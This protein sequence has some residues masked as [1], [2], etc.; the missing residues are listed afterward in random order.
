MRETHDISAARCRESIAIVGIG[1]RMPGARDPRQLWANLRDGVASLREVPRERFDAAG[2]SSPWGGFVDDVDAFDAAFFGISPREATCMDPQQR[3]A[4]ETAWDALDDGGQRPLS[5]RGTRTGVF[6]GAHRSE[7]GDQL[8]SDLVAATGRSRSGIAG[9]ISFALGLEGP[10]VVLDT[11]RSSSL[12]ALLFAC[13]SLR[14][15]ECS[16]ALAGGVNL[17]LEPEPSL[18]FSR[19]NMLAPDGRIKFCDARA[20]GIARSDGIGIVALKP[21]SAAQRDGDAIYAVVLGGAINHDGGRSGDLM[22]PSTASQAALLRAACDDARVLPLDLQYVE[23]H[24]TGTVVGD[25]V[26]VEALAR[27]LQPGRAPSA[28]LRIGS[29]KTNLGHTEAAAGIAGVIKV[30]LA[31]KHRRLPASLH[32]ETPNP[33]IDFD[34]IVVQRETGAWPDE[35]RPLVAGVTSLGLTGVNAHAILAEAP[36]APRPVVAARDE[37]LAISARG[38]A[39]LFELAS[40]YLQRLR[41]D[42]DSDLTCAAATRRSHLEDRIAV[43]GSSPEELAHELAAVLETGNLAPPR[44]PRPQLRFVIRGEAQPAPGACVDLLAEDSAFR[45]AL[46]RCDLAVNEL[47]GSSLLAELG[48]DTASSRLAEPEL[49]RVCLVA[50]AIASAAQWRAWGI[51]ADVVTGTGTGT[52]AAAQIAGSVT[53]EQAIELALQGGPIDVPAHELDPAGHVVELGAN[54]TRRTLLRTLAALYTRGFDV[55]WTRVFGRDAGEV[56]LP[57]YPWRRDR[58]WAGREPKHEA[59]P[60]LA[61]VS[62][63]DHVIRELAGVLGLPTPEAIDPRRGFRELGVTSLL[64]MELIARLGTTLGR[65]LPVSV[66]FDHPNVEALAAHLDGVRPAT[67]TA[68]IEHSAEPIALVGIGC[69]FPGG[70]NS[71]D[72]FWN[73][74]HDGVDAI[75]EVPATRWDIE[76][77]YDPEPGQPGKMRTRWGGFLDDLDQFDAAFFGISPREAE[78]M[79]PQ[80]RLLLEVAWDAL[81]RA[82]QATERLTGSSVGVF[83]GLMNN[84]DYVARKRLLD[85][86]T[87]IRAAHSTGMATSIAAGRIA[88]LLGLT[89]PALAVDTACSSSLVAVHLAIRSLRAGEC[90]MALAGGANAIVSPELSVAYSQAGMLSPTGRCRTFS[91][92]AD[93]YVRSEGCGIVVLKR[94]ADAIA[95]GDSVLAVIAGAAVNHDGR[96][97]GLTAPNGTAQRAVVRAALADAG[98]A[99]ED[100]DYVEA[101]GTGTRLGDPIEFHALGEVFASRSRE[102]PVRVGSVKTNIGHLEAAAGIAGLIKVVLALQ[103]REMP[104]HLHLDRPSPLLADGDPPLEIPTRLTPWRARGRRVAGVSSFGFSGTNA[105]VVLAEAPSIAPAASCERAAELVVLSAK[106]ETALRAIAAEHA[107]H[108]EAHPELALGDVAFTLADGRSHHARRLAVVATSRAELAGALADVA[109]GRASPR[110][111]SGTATSGTKTAWLFTGQG[112]QRAGMGQ[113]LAAE[114]PVF[115]S[116]LAD[117]CAAVDAHLERSLRDVMWARPGTPDAALL[118]ETGYTQPALFALE[119]AL[120]ALWRSWGAEPDLVTGH[121]IGEIAAAHV[122]GVLSLDDAARLVAARA[123]LMQALPRGGAMVSIAAPEAEVAAAVAPHARSVAI[124]AINGPA[125]VVISGDAPTALAIA[126]GFARHGIRTAQLAVS[127]AFHSPLMEPMLDDFRAIAESVAYRAPRTP[128]VGNVTGAAWGAEVATADYWVRHVRAPVRFADGLAAL[129]RAGVRTFVELGPRPTLVGMVPACVPGDDHVLL[130]SLRPDRAEPVAILDALGGWYASGARVDWAPVCVGA[131]RRVELPTYAWDRQ[132]Y[133]LTPPPVRSE[134]ARAGGRRIELATGGT[135][136]EMVLSVA[137]QPWLADHRVGGEVVVPAAALLRLLAI[138]SESEELAAIAVRAPLRLADG[139]AREVQVV[140]DSPRVRLFSRS[141]DAAWTEHAEAEMRP[142]G[143][144]HA[145]SLAEARARCDQ[146]VDIDAAY[147]ALAAIGLDYGPAFRALRELA[148]GPGEVIARAVA[149]ESWTDAELGPLPALVDAAL[150]AMIAGA[151]Q[152]YLPFTFERVLVHGLVPAAAWISVRYTAPAGADLLAADVT[153]LDDHGR[154]IVSL[155]GCRAKRAELRAP[156]AIYRLAWQAIDATPAA[157]PAGR[158]LVVGAMESDGLAARVCARLREAGTACTHVDS[159]RVRDALPAEH[160]VYLCDRVDDALGVAT[161][162]LELAQ[163]LAAHTPAPRVW[164]MTRGATSTDARELPRIGAAALWGL[165]RT[166][167]HEH[168]E[169]RSVLVDLPAGEGA[170]EA[171]LAELATTDGETELAWRGGRRFAARLERATDGEC[172]GRALRTEGT[173]LVTGGLGGIGAH[174]ARWLAERG[175][176]HLVLAGRRGELTPGARELVDELRGRGALVTVAAVDVA[177]R[178][179]LSAVL[180]AIPAELPLRGVVHAAGTVDDGVLAEQTG[181]RFASVMAPKVAGAFHLD[182]LTREADLDAFV[183]FSS[184]AGTL[185]SAGQ[186]AYAAANAC[187]DALAA[188]RRAHGLAGLSLAWGPWAEVGMTAA[189]DTAQRQRWEDKGLRALAPAQALALLD[190]A[191]TRA[192]AHLV[193]APLDLARV[194]RAFDGAVPSPWRTLVPPTR[195]VAGEGW[196]DL[197]RAR[198][199]EQ[200][201][202]MALE[203]V[204][205]EIARVL[206]ASVD[207]VVADRALA[208]LGLDSLMA[209]E[210]RNA[211]GRRAGTRLPTTLAFDYPTP[212][213]IAAYLVAQLESAP[214]EEPATEVHAA[215]EPIAIVGYGCRFPG[216]VTDPD[217]FWRLLAGGVDAI[218]EVPADRWNVDAYYDPDPAAPGKMYTR[219]GGFLNGL[220]QFEPEFF[221]ISPREAVHMDPQ[222]RLLLE[223]SWEALERAGIAPGSLLGTNVGVFVGVMSHEYLELQGSDVARRDGYVTTG[224]LGAVASGRISYALGV[225]GPSMTIDTACSSSLVATHLACQALRAGECDVALAGGATVVLTPSLYVEFS[226]LRGLSRDGRCKSFSAA[227]DGVIWSEGCGVIALKRLRDAERDRDRV[228]GV[229]VGSAV[230]QDGRSQGLTA[231]NG[232]AQQDV[233]RRALAQAKLAPAAIDYVEAHGTG[234]RL[235]DPI[236]MQALGTALARDRAQPV[237]VGS[238]KSNIGHAQ[239]AAGVG[240]IIKTLLALEYE[241]IPRSLHFDAPSPH[242]AWNELPVKVAGEAVAWPRRT[243]RP[244]I[245]GISSF[246]ISGTNAHLLVQEPPQPPAERGAERGAELIVVSARSEAALAQATTEL[247]RHLRAHPALGLGA[248]AATLATGRAHHGH[249]VAVATRS[250]DEAAHALESAATRARPRTGKLAWLFTGQGSQLPGMGRELAEDW[251]VFAR[252]LERV[253]HAFD[254]LLPRPLLDVMWADTSGLLD[255]TAYTQP[256]L[257]ALEVALAAL[258]RSW[259]VQPDLLVGHSIGELAAAHVAGV[260]SLGDAARLVASRAR[261]MQALP[262]GGAMVSIAADEE[263]VAQ[264]VAAYANDVSIAAV[265][266]PTSVVISGARASVDGI[267]ESFRARGVRIWPLVVSHAFHSPLLDPML[268]EF[269]RVAESIAYHAPELALISN[270]TGRLADESVT[271]AAYWVDHARGAVRFAAG[272]R[273]AYEAGARTFLELGPKPTLLGLVPACVPEAPALLASLRPDRES[274]AA[275]ESLAE[276]YAQGRVIAWDGVFP[277]RTRPVELPTY[278]WQRASYWVPPPTASRERSSPALTAIDHPLLRASAARPDGDEQLF[279]AELGPAWLTEHRVFETAVLPGAAIVELA[280]AVGQQLGAPT[281]VELTSTAPVELTGAHQPLQ[282]WANGPD[283]AGRHRI[284]FYARMGDEWICH[285]RG[286]VAPGSGTPSPVTGWPPKSARPLDLA[287]LYARLA[288]TGLGYGEAFRGVCALWRDGNDLYARVELPVEA[289]AYLVHPALLDASLHALPFVLGTPGT[290]LLPFEWRDV[291]LHATGA[292]QLIVRLSVTEHGD[293]L[294]KVALEARDGAGEPVLRVGELILRRAS[295]DR[296]RAATAARPL[297]MYRVAWNRRPATTTELP[298][299]VVVGGSGALAS[300]L[301]LPLAASLGAVLAQSPGLVI[302]DATEPVSVDVVHGAHHCAHEA[303]AL[304]QTWLAQPHGELVWMTRSAIAATEHDGVGDLARAPLWGLLRSARREHAARAL[305]AIDLDAS[306]EPSAIRSALALRDATEL[307]VRGSELLAPQLAIAPPTT[308]HTWRCDGT[309]LVTGATGAL[310]VLVARHLVVEHGVRHLLLVSRSGASASGARALH[311]ELAGHGAR[312]AFAACDVSD[313]TAVATLLASIAPEAPLRAVFHCAGVVD[314]GLL[315]SLDGARIDRVFAAKLDAAVH[316]HELTRELPLDAFVLFSSIAGI[317]GTAGQA[318]YAAANAFLD[319][320]AAHRAHAGLAGQSLA[321]GL[322]EPSST[323]MTSTLS[324]ADLAR[325]R[326]QGIAPLSRA[327]GL[328]LLDEALARR[329]PLLV[330]AR[331]EQAASEPTAETLRVAAKVRRTADPPDALVALPAA[332]RRLAVRALVGAEASAVLRLPDRAVPEDEPLKSLG[333]DSMMALELADRLA[334]RLGVALPNTLAFDHPS[335]GQIAAFVDKVLP[336]ARDDEPAIPAVPLDMPADAIESMSNEELVNL[337][338]TL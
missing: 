78:E 30:A 176:R 237:I 297:P 25:P 251:P 1:L 320:L 247:A 195:T 225:Q 235:G 272:V 161:E 39:A 94:L 190:T 93:G 90:S 232:L 8:D 216:D 107:T 197:L 267:A 336:A 321:W 293:E 7:Y 18:A 249:R 279:I 223:T 155:S 16:L 198:P 134:P 188:H 298:P 38:R 177:D 2:L 118:D 303:L 172:T 258:W 302:V 194:R 244:R 147:D 313:R 74:L 260:F 169:L 26:E 266:G 196:L 329:T 213:A 64:G 11:D 102:R 337:V 222:Q 116:A 307:A 59:S 89:G 263:A 330:P 262:A 310:G 110:A 284:A 322:W 41:E 29:I 254:A 186:A 289:E 84:N 189:L 294:T 269:R 219:E 95:N 253:A 233:I 210:L 220:D 152:L 99:A 40:A 305:R 224:S 256:A 288:E 208:E 304:L 317:V 119:V 163:L 112:A 338:R 14:T 206:S 143:A 72:A 332:D 101:H 153:V 327:Q 47:A 12:V 124:A 45:A 175:V 276:L 271:T 171:V 323:G 28:A 202:A 10:S 164:W 299:A 173:V 62:A 245:A 287:D 185:G 79:D 57:V 203:L 218:R 114:W 214:I 42:R 156:D 167:M 46:V 91:A 17:V 154:A 273:A 44:T 132:S 70:A 75:R 192:D 88:Y 68:H 306:A 58:F 92:A 31:M 319:A 282:I 261:L 315:G 292:T 37:I 80:Q 103:H 35:T 61:G 23:A 178:A 133:W 191:W 21:L 334:R 283:A 60:P 234:T 159:T 285:A 212:G 277:D 66:L 209:L 120:A 4:L 168:P 255:Q 162:G 215:D 136:V 200:R 248:V 48:R 15:G 252:E 316:L 131:R 296:V 36:R 335:V 207:A 126:D 77:W 96:S 86:P 87:R 151:E 157:L 123:R 149:P 129:H 13:Q 128:G 130:T 300:R 325:I 32:F 49:A 281:L 141:G 81:E 106:T 82:G 135:V 259:G 27:V 145:V 165:A 56:E 140:L 312:V 160:V 53:I 240:G 73:R 181:A 34:G 144:P 286:V 166:A 221:E 20:N 205:A 314:D 174:T 137:E 308:A 52:I 111:I 146:R 158:W 19:A 250:L 109:R 280:L 239:A 67:I 85:D 236:E 241:L 274:H 264:A 226:R 83:L 275:L 227:A 170:V 33:R 22:T 231:P 238:L 331:L 69:R 295:A 301:G 50:I 71:P 180:A 24:G 125:S 211:L 184:V 65:S 278:P 138:A 187:L 318:N 9:R 265:N 97:S 229:I 179:A 228:H 193:L 76:R 108:L 150:Q 121:S 199:T 326:R 328:A 242:I 246:G 204:R 43:V 257:F 309:V 148:R 290:A 105:H 51:E 122:A 100:V 182:E 270:L 104:P 324:A 5:L 268:D 6:L 183:M 127:H 63:R 98:I 55:A 230:N 139:E 333:L 311:D 217:S 201:A 117:A 113:A 115:A 3:L 291:A 142:A 243:D 54:P